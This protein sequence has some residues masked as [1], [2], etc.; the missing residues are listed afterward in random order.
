MAPPHWPYTGDVAVLACVLVVVVT[1]AAFTFVLDA[2]ADVFFVDVVDVT[3]FVLE[4]VG[5][6]S[7]ELVF[8]VLDVVV[9]AA[10]ELDVVTA[11]FAAFAFFARGLICASP[12]KYV[13]GIVGV[14]I[15][16]F[17]ANPLAR[18]PESVLG[19]EYPDGLEIEEVTIAYEV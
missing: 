17:V 2:D 15:A 5:L 13:L 16:E 9:A 1:T 3:C 12:G 14:G 11:S 8:P 19:V 4:A 7:F 18:S 6:A 10:L